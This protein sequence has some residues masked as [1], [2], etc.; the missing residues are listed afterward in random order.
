MARLVLKRA[1]SNTSAGRRATRVG[2]A[3]KRTD[4]RQAPMANHVEVLKLPWKDILNE[5]LMLICGY[6]VDMVKDRE[7]VL[8]VT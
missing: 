1:R 8:K 4:W 3:R 2:R 6:V 7:E 5:L